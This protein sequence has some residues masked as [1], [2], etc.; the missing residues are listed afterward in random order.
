VRR[1]A[2][3]KLAQLMAQTAQSMHGTPEATDE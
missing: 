1:E 2:V 3:E